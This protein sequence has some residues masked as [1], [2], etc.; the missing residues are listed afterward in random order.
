MRPGRAGMAPGRT[1]GLVVKRERHLVTLLADGRKVDFQNRKC[2]YQK[3]L[4]RPG[5]GRLKRSR[6]SLLIRIGPRTFPAISKAPVAAFARSS[7]PPGGCD[8]E[9]FPSRAVRRSK[10]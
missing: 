6:H 2:R 9:S 1:R 4:A 7:W 3:I 5:S 10:S 8:I